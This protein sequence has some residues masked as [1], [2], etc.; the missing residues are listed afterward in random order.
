MPDPSQHICEYLHRRACV[1]VCVYTGVFLGRLTEACPCGALMSIPVLVCCTS[2]VH[3]HSKQVPVYVCA[4]TH[5]CVGMSVWVPVL[6]HASV[7]SHLGTRE[8]GGCTLLCVTLWPQTVCR[9]VQIHEC[10]N[11]AYGLVCIFS[12][13]KYK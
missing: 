6:V 2:W 8:Q 3:V 10:A 9:Q 13:S 5:L 11:C 1:C 4:C 7:G 12:N